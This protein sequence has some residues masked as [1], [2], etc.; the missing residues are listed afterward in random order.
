MEVALRGEVV[1]GLRTV[2][3]KGPRSLPGNDDRL[4]KSPLLSS[5]RQFPS[6]AQ[7]V[8]GRLE[9]RWW[10]GRAQEA[11]WV[12]DPGSKW[13]CQRPWRAGC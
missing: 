7:L 4:K 11:R 12:G 6:G 3:Q 2:I 8:L 5:T 9:L 10:P 1:A 13:P